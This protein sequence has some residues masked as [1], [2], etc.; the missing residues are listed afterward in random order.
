[1][2][3]Q[4]GFKNALDTMNIS[5]IQEP[6]QPTTNTMREFVKH[7]QW[8]KSIN[9]SGTMLENIPE[10]KRKHFADEAKTLDLYQMKGFEVQW[11]ENVR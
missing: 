5:E 7:M 4:T 11:N 1:M 9:I 8:L 3:L 6:K 10:I 2:N